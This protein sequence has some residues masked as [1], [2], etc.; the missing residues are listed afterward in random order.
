[1][2]TLFA[3]ALVALIFVL[4]LPTA[5]SALGLEHPPGVAAQAWIPMGESAGFV[6]TGSTMPRGVSPQRDRTMGVAQPALR[7]YFAVKRG[8]AWY[9]IDTIPEAGIAPT[10][11]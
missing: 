6:V 3:I 11:N 1:M 10:A 5:R 2:K 9:R 7:G 4:A 8:N